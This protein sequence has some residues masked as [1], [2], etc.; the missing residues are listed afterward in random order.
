MT[1]RT[2]L[3]QGYDK[4][5]LAEVDTPLLDALLLLAFALES[6][7]EKVLASLPEEVSPDAEEHFLSLLDR[8]SSGTPLSYI[9]RVKEFWG[10]EFYVDERVLVP[11]PDTETLVEKAVDVV[12]ADPRLHRVH[13]AC[14]GSGCI[15]IA[16]QRT[17]PR[18]EVSASDL[19]AEAGEVLGLNAEKLL[20]RRMDFFLS[21]LLE[22]VPGSFDLITANPPYLRDEEVVDMRKISWPE[23]EI[24]LR[25][26]GDG[27]ALAVR[28]IRAAPLKLGASGWLVMEAAPHQINK[29]YALMDQAGF[30]SIDVVQDLAGRN[31]VI[32]G[33]LGPGLRGGRDG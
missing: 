29:L 2:L 13:D 15:G 26:G 30:H 1:V 32:A 9:R 14:A 31:R 5:F 11:R 17:V 18:L 3:R 12:R 23:P 6:T 25:G 21:D 33:R 24:A 19:S 7:K 8:R 27:T 22:N 20:G 4:L 28:L 10:L 16:L